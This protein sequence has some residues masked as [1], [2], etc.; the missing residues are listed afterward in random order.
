MRRLRFGSEAMRI[1]IAES[2]PALAKR[3]AQSLRGLT[4][5]TDGPEPEVAVLT[6]PELPAA[7]RRSLP[8]LLVVGLAPGVKPEKVLSGLPQPGCAVITL[9][10]DAAP[11]IRADCLLAGAD[12]CLS[13]PL[14]MVELRARCILA[15]RR[16]AAEPKAASILAFG[17]LTIDRLS[18]SAAVH[19]RALALTGRELLILE[20]LALAAGSLVSRS[21]LGRAVWQGGAGETNALDV[22]LA[23]LRRKLRHSAGAP[24]I[25]TVRGAGF[26]LLAACA[27]QAAPC[28]PIVDQRPFFA[29]SVA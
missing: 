19:G 5:G 28:V 21:T 25:G 6:L 18:R 14:S 17:H 24:E 12:D 27:S 10:G 26:Q 22:H 8:A 3:L 2:E 15:L 23:A 16:L 11:E 29:A 9:A 7:A 4:I 13:K 20:Q 1:L